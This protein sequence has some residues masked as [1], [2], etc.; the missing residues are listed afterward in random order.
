MAV[1]D[2]R[3]F[4]EGKIK[5]SL[6]IL[7]LSYV[8]TNGLTLAAS[9]IP[10]FKVAAQD[11]SSLSILI[12]QD[13]TKDQTKALIHE[14]KNARK[15][16]NLSQM[17]PPTT[18]GGQ[19]GDYAIIWVLIFSEPEWASKDKLIKFMKSSLK[20]SQD[21]KFDREYVKHIKAE[22]FYSVPTSEEYGNLGYDDGMIQ[23][24]YYQKLF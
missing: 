7:F 12:P 8:A 16:K 3:K 24:P 21:K 4:V 15:S 20:S 6:V 10:K 17:I 23:S 19:L 5:F 18:K 11:M 1:K 9:N 2:H 13:T 22:Y 14:F